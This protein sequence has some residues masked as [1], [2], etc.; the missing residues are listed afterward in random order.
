MDNSVLKELNDVFDDIK[1]KDNLYERL[2]DGE[3]LA[4][5]A[6]IVVGESKSEKPM[7][8]MVFEVT[9]GKFTGRQHRKFLM[10]SGKDEAQLKQNL[11]RYATEVKK[12]GVDTGKGLN[13]TFE[14]LQDKIGTEVKL[15]I[16]TTI[17]K[18][19]TEWFNTSFNLVD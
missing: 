12:L 14:Q 3:Y 13:A 18:N 17:N 9:H 7:V 10:L 19:G 5:I 11:H 4:T 15:T 16:S 2:A 1:D 8:T 6:D